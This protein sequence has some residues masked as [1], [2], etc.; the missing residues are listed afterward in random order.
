MGNTL[1]LLKRINDRYRKMSKGQ[2]LLATYISEQYSSAVFFTAAQLGDKVGV[3]ESTV[4]RFATSL[5]YK[6]YPEF[7][8]AMEELVQNKLNHSGT[9]DAVYEN[10]NQNEILSTVLRTDAKRVEETLKH[11]DEDAFELAVEL[12]DSSK[13]I[14]IIGLRSCAPLAQFLSFYLSLLYDHVHLISTSSSSE[15]FEQMVHIGKNDVILGISFPRYS[16]RTLKALEYANN[17][18]AKV[19]TLTDSI[20]SPMNL[21]SSC[22]LV[23]LSEMSS[24]VDSLTAPLS[25]INALIISLYMRRSNQVIRNLDELERIWNDYQVYSSDEI[26]YIDDSMKMRYR[27]PEKKQ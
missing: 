24:V 12:L 26:D 16:L 27:R 19:I 21:Y 5:G 13:N 22:N 25:V 11:I 15:L 1:D 3:S 10:L 23:A 6:G 17:K 4:V 9:T 2:K 8:K 18:N 14:Y 20:H 7:Q